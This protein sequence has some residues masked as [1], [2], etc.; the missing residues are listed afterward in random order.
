[1][2]SFFLKEPVYSEP[3]KHSVLLV[4]DNNIA[5]RANRKTETL[6]NTDNL[7]NIWDEL[8]YP[9]QLILQMLSDKKEITT[10]DVERLINRGK[11]TSVKH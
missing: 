6:K 11:T 4:L 5:V 9:E 8:S 1:M 2:E 3:D 10:S 7:K